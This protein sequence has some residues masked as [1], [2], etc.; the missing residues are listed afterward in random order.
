MHDAAI[1]CLGGAAL[2]HYAWVV[3]DAKCIVVTRICVS[4]CL[5]VCVCLWLHAYTI[6]RTG[7]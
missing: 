2:L 5:C 4:V 6:A 7:M 1:M 3:D